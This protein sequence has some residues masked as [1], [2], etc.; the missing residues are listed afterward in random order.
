[1]HFYGT[2]TEYRAN[3]LKAES[4]AVNGNVTSHA[5]TIFLN[6]LKSTSL[7]LRVRA[8]PTKTTEPTLQCVVLIGSPNL[9]ARRTVVAVPIS[10]VKPLKINKENTLILKIRERINAL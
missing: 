7:V 2:V 9:E 3:M 4:N 8:Q 10:I 5:R 6:N 1:M